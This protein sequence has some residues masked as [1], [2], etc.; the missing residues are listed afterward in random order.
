MI[1]NFSVDLISDLNLTDTDTFDWTGKQTSL[2]CVVA[3]NISN[4]LKVLEE[5]LLNISNNYL[6]ILFIDGSLEHEHLRDYE[7]RVEEIK[8]ICNNINNVVY[9][10]NHAVIL[11]DIAFIGCNGW[12]GNRKDSNCIDELI[13]LEKYRS[14]DLSYVSMCIKKFQNSDEIKKIVIVSNS[15]PNERLTFN[16]SS[17]KFPEELNL[18]LWLLFDRDQKVTSWLFGTNI[19]SI[20]VNILNRHYVNNSGISGLIYQPKRITF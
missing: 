1:N 19:M 20:D 7:I 13:Y 2:F 6:G 16:N 9:L 10:H 4:D 11:N 12:Y 3:G 18:S 8:E 14:E 17:V 5:T 15:I